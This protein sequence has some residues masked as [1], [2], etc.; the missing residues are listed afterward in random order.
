MNPVKRFAYDRFGPSIHECQRCASI[1]DYVTN[2][3]WPMAAGY[4][5][6]GSVMYIVGIMGYLPEMGKFWRWFVSASLFVFETYAITRP[7]SPGLGTKFIN[8]ILSTSTNHPPYLPFQLIILLRKVGLTLYIAFTQIGPLLQSPDRQPQGAD[9]ELLLREQLNRLSYSATAIREEAKSMY[10]LAM[11]PFESNPDS[12]R[13]VKTKV[14][15]WAFNNTVREERVV[16]DAA[17]R[18]I[19]RRRI[20][21]PA[22]AIGNR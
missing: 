7:Y 14:Q 15:N 4:L 10:Q 6:A 1:G 9:P 16:K 11:V 19:Q 22:G 21:A 12:L 5:G 17:G 20:G 2:G 3:F 18:V 13:E 8:P